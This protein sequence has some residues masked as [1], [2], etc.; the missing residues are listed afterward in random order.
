M[1]TSRLVAARRSS[2]PVSTGSCKISHHCGLGGVSTACEG[3]GAATGCFLPA[4]HDEG[5]K[6]LGAVKSGPI[7]QPLKLEIIMALAHSAAWVERKR[8]GDGTA[9]GSSVYHHFP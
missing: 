9:C 6:I 8:L 4:N 5:A 1:R 2:S 7:A 3:T